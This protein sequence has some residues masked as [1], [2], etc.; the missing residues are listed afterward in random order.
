MRI[1][2]IIMPPIRLGNL[3]PTP[4]PPLMLLLLAVAFFCRCAT[5]FEPKDVGSRRAFLDGAKSAAFAAAA[6]SS[7][8]SPIPSACAYERRD[9]GDEKTR[10][11][12]TAAMNDQ[13]YRT[14]NRLEASGFKLDTREEEQARLSS[15]MASFSYDDATSRGKGGGSR[16]ST[17]S[18]SAKKK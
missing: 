5:S 17:A 6:C 16:P 14:N 13:A 8:A 11:A 18:A 3:L 2:R 4:P 10:S 15:A 7:F 1:D 9:V 12:D